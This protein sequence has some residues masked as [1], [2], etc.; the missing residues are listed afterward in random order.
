MNRF[1]LLSSCDGATDEFI[2]SPCAYDSDSYEVDD[3]EC[4][5][6]QTIAKSMKTWMSGENSS[7]EQSLREKASNTESFK[8]LSV[9][10]IR[11]K[12]KMLIDEYLDTGALYFPKTSP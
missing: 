3:D 1:G 8:G 12:T 11:Q 7:G 10:E 4:D 5:T 9:E 6:N 2:K